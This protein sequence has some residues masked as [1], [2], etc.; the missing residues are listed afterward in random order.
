MLKHWKHY[1]NNNREKNKTMVKNGSA[2]KITGAN[3]YVQMANS[4]GRI[5][6]KEKKDAKPT[7][8][9]PNNNVRKALREFYAKKI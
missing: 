3:R 6:S 7:T 1:I 4:E 9:V 2:P 5:K 8:G